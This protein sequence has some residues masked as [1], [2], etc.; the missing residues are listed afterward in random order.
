MD[1]SDK[2]LLDAFAARRSEESF[3][4]QVI[5]HLPMVF[6]GA[7]R[8]TDDASLAEEIAQ[9]TFTKLANPTVPNARKRPGVR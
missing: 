8:V 4:E 7:F 3:R 5:R 2:D 1:V 6:S 9:S